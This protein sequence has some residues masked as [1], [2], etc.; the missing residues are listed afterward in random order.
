[1]VSKIVSLSKVDVDT[2]PFSDRGF[3]L[4]IISNTNH[5]ER[6]WTFRSN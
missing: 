1:M 5:V 4:S 6:V 2:N 3:G